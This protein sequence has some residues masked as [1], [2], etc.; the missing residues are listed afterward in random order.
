MGTSRGPAV[1]P[2]VEMARMRGFGVVD[3]VEEVGRA[4]RMVEMAEVQRVFSLRREYIPFFQ[5]G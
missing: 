1:M 5:D 4:A 3:G 2:V